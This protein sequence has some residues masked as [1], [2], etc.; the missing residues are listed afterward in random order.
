MNCTLINVIND[1][2]LE[3][4]ETVAISVVP[5]SRDSAVVRVSSSSNES[6]ITIGNDDGLYR[7][8]S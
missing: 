2:I 1:T 4:N 5:S 3:N 6:T 7:Y 8:N